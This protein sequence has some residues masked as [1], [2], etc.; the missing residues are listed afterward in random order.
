MALPINISSLIIETKET[1]Y[2][3]TW[4]IMGRPNRKKEE[5]NKYEHHDQALSTK[6]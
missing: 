2:L 6:I 4:E 3:P 5:H 1:S